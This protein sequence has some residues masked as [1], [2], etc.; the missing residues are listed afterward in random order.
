MFKPLKEAFFILECKK[1]PHYVRSK[2]TKIVNT[3]KVPETHSRLYQ[4]HT[5]LG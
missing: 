5:G 3:S 1:N 4:K 2:R